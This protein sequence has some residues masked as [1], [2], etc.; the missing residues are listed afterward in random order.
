MPTMPTDSNAKQ[1]QQ[2]WHTVK[3]GKKVIPS[4]PE[5]PCGSC[6][7][8][9]VDDN[10]I[11]CESCNLWF[12]IECENVSSDQ[13][14]ML[15][16]SPM[17][18]CCGKCRLADGKFDFEAGLTRLGLA[19]TIEQLHDVVQI[20]QIYMKASSVG[21]ICD[22]DKPSWAGQK[23]DLPAQEILGMV[24]GAEAKELIP[25]YVPGDGNCLFHSISVA[26]VGGISMTMELRYRVCVEIVTNEQFY[27]NH[28][29]ITG[30][31][32]AV[33]SFSAACMDTARDKAWSTI[34]Q[35]HGLATVTGRRI[36]SI[37]PSINGLLDF[38]VRVLNLELCPRNGITN[39]RR[40]QILWTKFGSV[41]AGYK[42][43]LGRW[44]PDHF[45]FLAPKSK[46]I[47]SYATVVSSPPGT[48]HK[49]GSEPR[50]QWTPPVISSPILIDDS[51][52]PAN[53]Y[54]KVLSSP[55]GRNTS[56]WQPWKAS[57]LVASS[58][59]VSKAR[60]RWG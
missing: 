15:S 48:T 18:F 42:P 41:N 3:K 35:M 23:I 56:P 10:T 45:V 16:R 7:R 14:E 13:F 25:L 46:F 29:Q 8:E 51:P 11:L 32:G 47:P 44:E 53:S 52:K 4:G 9:C 30:A 37:Y 59:I 22:S 33:G 58:P 19:K 2:S 26:L 50:E 34:W 24:G 60:K 57:V 12:H 54:A 55:P 20:E 39:P 43:E 17:P 5:Y 36:N 38:P 40:L 31:A 6:F 27:T 21:N 28:H 1:K 49:T